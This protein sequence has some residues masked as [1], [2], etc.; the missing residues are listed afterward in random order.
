MLLLIVAFL[1][2]MTS[3][4]FLV[5]FKQRVNR[6]YTKSPKHKSKAAQQ[7]HAL[8]RSFIL[9]FIHFIHTC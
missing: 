1:A 9:L 5:A 2:I 3:Y 8:T 7:I 6:E 4:S